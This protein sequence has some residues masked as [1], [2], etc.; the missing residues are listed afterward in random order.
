MSTNIESKIQNEIGFIALINRIIVRLLFL[1]TLYTLVRIVYYLVHRQDF[2]EVAIFELAE[3]FVQGVRFDLSTLILINFPFLLIWIFKDSCFSKIR[4]FKYSFLFINIL[5][6]WLN[7]ADIEW[8]VFNG[9]RAAISHFLIRNDIAHQMPQ[10]IVHYWYLALFSMALSMI[11]TV[12]FPYKTIN[13]NLKNRFFV[14]LL[15]LPLLI[16]GVRGGF[17]NKPLKP[18]HAYAYS[19]SELGH[20]V[21]NSTFTFIHSRKNSEV[22]KMAWLSESEMER[23][24]FSKRPKD[25]FSNA[26]DRPFK[27]VVL[28]ILES[29]SMEYIGAANQGVGYTP[30]FDQLT[31]QGLF[32]RNFFANGRR[33]IEAVPSMM[34]GIP[35][36]MSD[37]FLTSNFQGSEIKGLPDFLLRYNYS[38]GF[39]HGAVNG[40]MF[41]DSFAA[42]SGFK[43]YFGLS[44]YPEPVRD[45]DGFWGVYDEPFFLWSKN[46]ISAFQEPFFVTLFSLSSHQPYNVPLNLKGRFP[47]GT[48]EIH[49]SIGYTDYALEQ[50][51]IA[52]KK[53]SWY[54]DTLFIITG[55]H[56]SKSD[57]SNYQDKIGFYRVPL[58]LFAENIK[59]PK[60]DLLQ[61]AQHIDIYPTILHLLGF[62]DQFPLKIGRS[63]FDDQNR[64]YAMNRTPEGFWFLSNSH[65]TRMSFS[66]EIKQEQLRP[67]T[68]A[69]TTSAG[70]D[71]MMMKAHLQYLINGLIENRLITTR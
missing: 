62:G 30:F 69:A 21:L 52:A 55:D 10:L 42:R 63:L 46:Q 17:Q 9:Q 27:N 4:L 61:P 41:F 34:A 36:W 19:R 70:D 23:Y 1:M 64:A 37:A 39:F 29:F 25:V 18:T 3:A 56:T 16:L 11:I 40:S 22:K 50:F 14:S 32:F 20:L 5:F 48:L 49:E 68:Q 33:S 60:L 24:L 28:I 26:E 45:Y 59:W 67:S 47:K 54:K 13:V 31:K 7:V 43:K 44:E 66:D 58:L 35:S 6:L 8:I 51:F 57:N 65:F 2:K 15:L 12:Y 71:E 53:E 38:S